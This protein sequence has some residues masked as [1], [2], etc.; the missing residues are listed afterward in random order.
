MRIGNTSKVSTC[1]VH[2][3]HT[4]EPGDLGNDTED[5]IAL[6]VML[7]SVNLETP[8]LVQQ[9]LPAPRA[10]LKVIKDGNGKAQRYPKDAGQQWAGKPIMAPDEQDPEFMLELAKV[11][12]LQ[13]FAMFL[14]ATRPSEGTEL[15][16]EWDTPWPDTDAGE[17]EPAVW[18]L[19]YESRLQELRD[20]GL[21]MGPIMAACSRVM[22]LQGINSEKLDEA[23]QA[24]S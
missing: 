10:K 23:A 8:V 17:P 3:L 12:V 4:I 2:T 21:P 24:F 14:E 6:E 13:S 15:G 7:H 11:N 20:F 19:F 18:R 5:P 9:R 22:S 16:I 1:Q